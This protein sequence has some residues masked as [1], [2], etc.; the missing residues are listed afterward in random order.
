V[1]KKD[2]DLTTAVG[3]ETDVS[4]IG[5][6]GAAPP[7]EQTADEDIDVVDWDRVASTSD[8]ETLVESR[9]RFLIPATVF[10]LIYYFVL[11]VLVGFYPKV[12]SQTIS[13]LGSVNL[14]YLF[15]LSQFLMVGLVAWAYLR[16]AKRFD[17]LASKVRRE[18]I[19]DS[20]SKTP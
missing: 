11:L 7:H 4:R 16:H 20:E 10:F 1:G 17:A 2:L 12:M 19:S 13:W 18:A 6:A 3:A 14:A 15:A 8:F 9:A 5:R